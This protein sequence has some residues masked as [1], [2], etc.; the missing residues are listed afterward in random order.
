[1]PHFNTLEP[2]KP[3]TKKEVKPTYKPSG[4]LPMNQEIMQK[5]GDSVQNLTT[6][7]NS[8]DIDQK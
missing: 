2:T 7:D 6:K 5:S 8:M 1:M 4:Q 3:A